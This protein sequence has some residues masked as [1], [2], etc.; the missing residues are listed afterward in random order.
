[1]QVE[2]GKRTNLQIDKNHVNGMQSRGKIV[3]TNH[4]F[5]EDTDKDKNTYK[6]EHADEWS[7]ILGGGKF[8]IVEDNEDVTPVLFDSQDI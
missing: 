6:K 3:M 7:K 8:E 5:I 2:W 1:M 4:G